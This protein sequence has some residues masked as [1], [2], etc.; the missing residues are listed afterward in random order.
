[1]GGYLPGTYVFT[2]I[3]RLPGTTSLAFTIRVS[4]LILCVT[5]ASKVRACCVGLWGLMVMVLPSNDIVMFELTLVELTGLLV[6]IIRFMVQLSC[7]T[8]G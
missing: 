5:L 6:N 2:L 3:V 1:M 7:L 4:Q 8:R